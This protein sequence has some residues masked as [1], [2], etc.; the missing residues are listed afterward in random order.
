M[1]ETIKVQLGF[2]FFNVFN[3]ATFTV[4]NNNFRDTGSFGRFDAALQARVIQYRLKILF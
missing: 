4:P 1:T 2:E 3:Q